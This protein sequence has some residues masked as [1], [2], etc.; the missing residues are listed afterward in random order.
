MTEFFRVLWLR[1]MRRAPEPVGLELGP[2]DELPPLPPPLPA[3]EP[4]AKP[5]RE[6]KQPVD[7]QSFYFREAILDSLDNYFRHLRNMRKSDPDA[8]ELYSKIGAR[9]V[10]DTG[11]VEATFVSPWFRQTLPSFGAVAVIIGTKEKEEEVKHDR[12]HPRFLTF[13][14]YDRYHHPSDYQAPNAIGTFYM[15]G[16]YWDDP[17]KKEKPVCTTLGVCLTPEGN[18][19]PLKYRYQREVA[20]KHKK[21]RL[22][23]YPTFVMQ[24]KWRLPDYSEAANEHGV[25]LT[26]ELI[27]RFILAANIFETAHSGM[28]EVTIKSPKGL[29][30]KFS[31]DPVR[32]AYFFKDREVTLNAKGRKQKIFHIVRTHMRQ[33]ADG[34][35]Q[36][37]KTHFR[38]LRSFMWNGYA[39]SITVPNREHLNFAEINVDAHD[40]EFDAEMKEKTI[41]A[42]EIADFLNTTIGKQLDEHN[43]KLH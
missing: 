11:L 20:I 37:V 13:T 24:T 42:G 35:E 31:V 19:I 5:K 4:V 28:T 6:K 15:V 22:R 9:I 33:R 25:T 40:S 18:A 39:V 17:K 41:G 1:L 26:D 16:M 2:L 29:V 12:I 14:K 10:P 7:S 23:D 32:T 21:G 43:V 30:A 3:P 36:A 8:F 34:K 27:Q 38:G